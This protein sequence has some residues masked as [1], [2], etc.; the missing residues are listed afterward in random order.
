MSKRVK[1]EINLVVKDIPFIGFWWS[2]NDT[3]VSFGLKTGMSRNVH[4]TV[5]LRNNIMNAHITDTI[6]NP[7]KVWEM[8]ISIADLE[9]IAKEVMTTMIKK[10]PW[11]R[12]YYQLNE[13]ILDKMG[14]SPDKR[15]E[16]KRNWDMAET[17][18]YHYMDDILVK[19]RMRKALK[20]G[21]RPGFIFKGEE[22]YFVCPIDKKNMFIVN[23]EVQKT[24]LW[25]IPTV[26][27]FFRF[28]D[29]LDEEKIFEQFAQMNKEK[30]EQMK[31]TLLGVLA[32]AG[33]N[34]D[35]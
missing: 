13:Y 20:E 7:K 4:F 5:Y 1:D 17:I 34:I 15:E 33:I 18:K 2:G 25:K 27:G 24:P 29:Y 32:E 12:R 21:F 14:L 16:T 11:Y 9:M 35:E 22:T 30:M 19:R 23:A 6:K 8:E 31:V 26:Q 3:G 10:Y 28:M